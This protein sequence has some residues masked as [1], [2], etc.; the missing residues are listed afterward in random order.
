MGYN[1]IK[2]MTYPL[3]AFGGI[4]HPQFGKHHN[5]NQLNF[6]GQ[7]G[8]IQQQLFQVNKDVFKI[9]ID[10]SYNKAQENN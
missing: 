10:N 6:I 7:S 9:K 8:I 3:S 5:V 4:P 1:G 2:P